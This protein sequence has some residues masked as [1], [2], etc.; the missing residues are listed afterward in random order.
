MVSTTSRA[1][2]IAHDPTE[3]ASLVGQRLEQ[4][5]FTLT[6]HVVLADMGDSRSDEPFPDPGAFDLV[7]V[8]G[9]VH[10]VYDTDTIGSWI[11]RELDF[12]RQAD[13]SGVPVLGICFG[14]QALAAAHGGDV[15]PGEHKQ[16]GWFAVPSPHDGLPAGPWMQW[17]YDRFEAPPNADVLS[18]DAYGVQAFTLRRNLGVQF[19]PEVDPDHLQRWFDNGGLQELDRLGLDP[20]AVMADAKVHAD[21]VRTGRLVDWFLSQVAHTRP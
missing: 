9:S 16:V 3:T 5:G 1:V 2:V 13:R 20:Q 11:G 15:V 7:V 8:M 6:E 21:P 19:H 10:S 17:H 18:E 4:H 12:L 14:G